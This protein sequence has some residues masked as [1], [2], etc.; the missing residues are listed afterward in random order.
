MP[1]YIILCYVILLLFFSINDEYIL[2]IHDEKHDT[3]EVILDL[4]GVALS[5]Q[6]MSF[7]RKDGQLMRKRKG[8]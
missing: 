6:E 4:C 5:E 1:I 2:G 8:S 3:R 7:K